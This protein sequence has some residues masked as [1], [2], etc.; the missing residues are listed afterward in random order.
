MQSSDVA[1]DTMPKLL[2]RNAAEFGDS[3]AYREKDLG[4]WQTWTW[5]EAS[6]EVM[7]LAK[8]LI[9]LG[10]KEGDHVAVIGRNRPY[11]YWS[12]LATQHI[13]A[14][15]VPLYQ[16][17]VAEEME[18]ILTHCNATFAIVGDQEQVDKI[19]EI[20]GSLKGF[21]DIVYVDPKGLRKYDKEK[22]HD[23]A[24]VVKSGEE[25]N[26]TLT[27]ELDRRVAKIDGDTTCVLCYTS[28]TTGM[29]K[30]VVQTHKA[31]IGASMAAV[32]FDQ[33]NNKI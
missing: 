29:S 23:F 5:K 18:Y 19:Y 22:L 26:S 9:K 25:D 27:D 13:G 6:S 32:D 20:S 4:I 16:D 8:G 31:I 24:S 28:G 33:F 2:A 14:V 10:I 7:K 30:G 1:L 17:A 12:L 11:L 3:P 21:K 15:P